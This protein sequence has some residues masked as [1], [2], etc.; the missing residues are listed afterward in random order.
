MQQPR[1]EN[2]LKQ[3]PFHW[4]KTRDQ[5]KT[6]D[7]K[8]W[9]N[10]Y[11]GKKWWA[12]KSQPAPSGTQSRR[13]VRCEPWAGHGHTQQEEHKGQAKLY[14]GCW[15]SSSAL[16]KCYTERLTYTTEL[17][18]AWVNSAGQHGLKHPCRSSFWKRA[19]HLPH[20]YVQREIAAL[21]FPSS[22]SCSPAD[23]PVAMQASAETPR[24]SKAQ[25]EN[26]SAPK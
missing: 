24:S 25:T 20:Y 13:A 8:A 2:I 19:P 7:W 10:F 6:R 21:C 22:A 26:I 14:K 9:R 18:Q 1:L 11:P 5:Q 3:S 23:K 4:K 15:A 12:F 16:Q 17:P